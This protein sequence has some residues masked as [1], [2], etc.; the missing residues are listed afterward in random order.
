MSRWPGPRQ[1]DSTA[2]S[3]HEMAGIIHLFI[4]LAFEIYNSAPKRVS[5]YLPLSFH[6]SLSGYMFS[7]DGGRDWWGWR[8]RSPGERVLGPAGSEPEKD[9]LLLPRPEASV[10][11]PPCRAYSAAPLPFS[12]RLL[13]EQLSHYLNNLQSNVLTFIT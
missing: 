7:R 1:P 12:L 4:P 9:A 3:W 5:P 13:A 10:R 2:F 6:P 8:D 11:S